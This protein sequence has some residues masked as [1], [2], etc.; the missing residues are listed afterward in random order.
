MEPAQ[1]K[2]ARE[3]SADVDKRWVYW[4][5]LVSEMG[6][7]TAR[8]KRRRGLLEIKE[9]DDGD[10]LYR[11][12]LESSKESVKSRALCFDP[13]EQSCAHLLIMKAFG[14]KEVEDC[15]LQE[16]QE[17]GQ[18]QGSVGGHPRHEHWGGQGLSAVG[19]LF[20]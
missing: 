9:D 20:S 5:G 10:K 1:V 4:K 3:E 15:G 2:V 18:R 11:L 13:E 6:A 17:D 16:D 19:A 12:K 8:A 7:K 14:S